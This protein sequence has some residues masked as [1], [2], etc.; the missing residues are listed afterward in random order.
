MVEM[1]MSLVGMMV[2]VME[3]IIEEDTKFWFL[4]LCSYLILYP[5][6]EAFRIPSMLP[7]RHQCISS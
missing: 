5:I 2:V 6:R 4:L 3:M 1:M 7:L